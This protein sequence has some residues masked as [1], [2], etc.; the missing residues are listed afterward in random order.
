MKDSQTMSEI[1]GSMSM[2]DEFADVARQHNWNVQ[3]I[4]KL[5]LAKERYYNAE[6]SKRKLDLESNSLVDINILL[7]IK[8][9]TVDLIRNGLGKSLEVSLSKYAVPRKEIR[10]IRDSV[11]N[12]LVSIYARNDPN[13]T[14]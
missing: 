6:R 7:T 5:M 12:E 2:T 4:A 1:S 14:K 9:E 11:Y 13:A 8:D 3:D 10:A